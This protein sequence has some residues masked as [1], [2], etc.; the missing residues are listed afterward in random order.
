MGSQGPG[1][2]RMVQ[3]G[4]YRVIDAALVSTERFD[5]QSYESESIVRQHLVECDGGTKLTTT[6]RYASWEARDTVLLYPMA[7]GVSESYQRLDGVLAE[8]LTSQ[9]TPMKERYR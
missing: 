8:S 6:I 2:E 5:D 3:S 7:R 9:K 1:S 4:V